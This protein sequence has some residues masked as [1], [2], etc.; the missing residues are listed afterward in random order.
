VDPSPADP[1]LHYCYGQSLNY[2]LE[3]LKK[4]KNRNT[5][6][7]EPKHGRFTAATTTVIGGLLKSVKGTLMKRLENVRRCGT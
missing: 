5:G 3:L 2:L 6:A 4:K 1:D 7:R